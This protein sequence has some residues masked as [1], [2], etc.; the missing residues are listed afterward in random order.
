MLID[1]DGAIGKRFSTVWPLLKRP[2]GGMERAARTGKAEISYRLTATVGGIWPI[3]D[4]PSGC[5]R[6]RGP[7]ED[8]VGRA[9]VQSAGAA[10]PSTPALYWIPTRSFRVAIPK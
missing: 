10:S 4:A 1:G 7:T 9:K 8:R 2:V 6:R 5:S 3:P